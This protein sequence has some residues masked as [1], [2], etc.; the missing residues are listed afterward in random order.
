MDNNNK[1]VQI[2]LCLLIALSSCQ[3]ESIPTH[4]YRYYIGQLKID[5][6]RLVCFNNLPI[7]E[8]QFVCP[9]SAT[10]YC[11]DPDWSER[12]D[13]FPYFP[14]L[15]E[16]FYFDMDQCYEKT[17]FKHWYDCLPIFYERSSYT[18]E[19]LIHESDSITISKFF[20][21]IN[22][23]EA[24]MQATELYFTCSDSLTDDD[25]ECDVFDVC[26]YNDKYHIVVRQH[27]SPLEY[28]ILRFVYHISGDYM[29]Y[30][31]LDKETF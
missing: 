29:L 16:Q 12:D 21:D 5:N 26:G 28:F 7:E 19:I 13:V 23:F 11:T 27:Y 3:N 14:I 31:P 30:R 15:Q 24:Y 20:F 17:Y 2:A 6:P 8:G 10:N 4:Y 9:D 22:T 18:H 1:F 25:S